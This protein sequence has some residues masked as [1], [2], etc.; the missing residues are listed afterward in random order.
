MVEK[1]VIILY[2]VRSPEI[3]W[4]AKLGLFFHYLAASD[5]SQMLDFKFSFI[6][7]LDPIWSK[8][9]ALLPS[10]LMSDWNTK[11]IRTI[12]NIGEPMII[13]NQIV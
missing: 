6:V 2:T 8:E 1:Y 10:N 5:L 3:I 13:L 12:S 11:G 4:K 9:I 7:H